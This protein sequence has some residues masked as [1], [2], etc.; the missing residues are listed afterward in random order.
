MNTEQLICELPNGLISWYPF[1]K[2]KKALYIIDDARAFLPFIKVLESKQL[3]VD[4]LTVEDLESQ[5]H[6]G[7]SCFYDYIVIALALEK[8]RNPQMLLG[9]LKPMLTDAGKLLAVVN[10]RFGIR[11]FCGDKDVYTKHVLDSIDDYSQVSDKRKAEIGGRTYDKA[12]WKEMLR[13][14]GFCR[15]KF[16]SVMPS[17]MR[18]QILISEDYTPNEVLDIR[19]F[20]QY[21]SP[22]TVFLEE[23]KLYSNLLRNGM[24][25]PMA[26]GYL[27]E[28]SVDG[29]LESADQITI[30]GD[31]GHVN[32]LVTV[33]RN[34]KSVTKKALYQEGRNKISDLNNNSIYL[35]EHHVPMAKSWLEQD[36]F[37]MPYV[38]GE[39][40]TLHFRKLL[41]KDRDLFLSEFAKFR[42][43]IV[44]SSEHVPYSEINWR[45]FEPWWEKRK[46]DDPNIDQWKN[47]AFGSREEQDN[48]GV[49]LKKGF[50]DLVSLNCFYTERGYIFFDQEFYVD[51]LPAN[52]ILVRTIDLIYRNCYELEQILPREEV[53]KRFKL[54]EYLDTWRKFTSRFMENLRSERQLEGYHKRFRRDW[55][56]VVAN[57]HRMDYPQEEYDR[58]FNNIFKGADNKK[59]YLFG[60]GKYA[61]QFIERFGKYCDIVGIVD[62]NSAK[63][64]N[65][66]CGIPIMEPQKLHHLSVPYKVFICIKFFEEVLEQL[67]EIG[68]K[69]VSVFDPRLDYD[70]PVR[71]VEKITNSE[72]KQYH[73][74]YVAGVF[75][76]FH[77][78]HLNL[79]RRAKEQCDYL[80]VGVVSDEQVIKSKKTSPYI[81]FEERREI[82]Q[83]CKYVDEAVEIPVNRPSTEDAW[84]MYHFDAQFSGSD[85]ANDPVWLAKKTFLQQHGSDLVFFPYTE[86]TSSTMLKEKISKGK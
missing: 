7:K 64:G 38:K 12:Q 31:R 10:N 19:V 83:A 67:K 33:I 22:Q 50:I 26:N 15:Q 71:I 53:F 54:W 72:P 62:N 14:A 60:S 79:L 3:E 46:A 40:A 85:Y 73:I 13:A 65:D 76:L 21:N 39:I 30:S 78:G 51:N 25:H 36:V 80:I 44:M 34:G 56:T 45:Q 84:R 74:G 9:I 37:V 58:I 61:E 16:Y 17:V 69:D 24:F 70:R 59:I 68:A 32:S 29:E 27:I 35:S 77:K 28:C 20:P 43:I 4:V 6:A 41:K 11:Y 2:D 82:V 81:P 1:E 18:P 52:V 57:R 5:I 23:E 48:I 55:N 42:E 47:R 63:W 66:L 49:I 8:S 75:D 86:S